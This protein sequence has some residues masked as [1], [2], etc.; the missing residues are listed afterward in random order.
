MCLIY[1]RT[2]Y[3]NSKNQSVIFFNAILNALDKKYSEETQQ[4]GYN[5]FWVLVFWYPLLDII[6]RPISNHLTIATSREY[7]ICF[8]K[9]TV[10]KSSEE[11]QQHEIRTTKTYCSKELKIKAFTE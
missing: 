3:Y 7:G 4:I 10:R 1:N 2:T 8:N 5:K 11:F 9:R 6:M